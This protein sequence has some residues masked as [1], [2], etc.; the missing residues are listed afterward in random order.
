MV[1][2]KCKPDLDSKT[3]DNDEQNQIRLANRKWLQIHETSGGV[4]TPQADYL[5]YTA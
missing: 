2:A 5:S 4:Q 1:Q 3:Q